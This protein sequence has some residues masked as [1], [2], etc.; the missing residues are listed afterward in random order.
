MSQEHKGIFRRL[1][2]EVFNQGI[3][4]A[5]DELVAEDVIEHAPGPDQGPGREGFK[6]FV[7]SFRRAFPDLRITVEDLIA[8]GDR[9]VARITIR[10]T[11]QGDFMG[12]APTGRAICITETNILRF[13]EG[14]I[15][16]HWGNGD[17]LGLLQQLGVLPPL[18]RA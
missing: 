3:L 2:D 17:D 5:V 9:A 8:E 4:A 16:E 6:H 14:K 15:V 7:R 11:H 12:A 10:G 13:Q 18:D 1:Y